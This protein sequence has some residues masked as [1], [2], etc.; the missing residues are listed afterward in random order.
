MNNLPAKLVKLRKHFHYSQKYLAQFLNISTVDYM[1]L[2]NGGTIASFA[3]IQ[4]LAKLYHLSTLV[5]FSNEAELI[6][7]KVSVSPLW[8]QKTFWL[9]IWKKFKKQIIIASLVLISITFL[10]FCLPDKK[11]AYI[12]PSIEPKEQFS[13]SDTSVV[14]VFGGQLVGSGDNSNGQL[15]LADKNIIKVSSGATFTVA[16][17]D[18]GKVVSAGLLNKVANDLAKFDNI[19]SLS[20]G[21]GHI[22]LL[23][24][25]GRAYCV[26]DDTYGQCEYNNIDKIKRIFAL[27]RASIFVKNDG[28]VLYCGESLGSS[29]LKKLKD[30]KDIASSDE[31]VIYLLENGEVG[32]YAKRDNFNLNNNFKDVVQ[33]CAGADFLAVLKADKTVTIDIDNYLLKQEV[34]SWRN[35]VAIAAGKDYL[36]ATDGKKLYGVGKNT[37]HQFK[38]TSPIRNTLP[39]VKNVN[40]KITE[41]E[42]IVQFSPVKNAYAYA[43]SIDVGTG[44]N[45]QT[46]ETTIHITNR[47][48]V[49]GKTYLLHIIAL[50]EKEYENS[51][52][53]NLDFTYQKPP[54]A[55]PSPSQEEIVEVPFSLECLTGKT[56]L[57]LEAYLIG[58]GVSKDNISSEAS[59]HICNSDEEI[60]ESI[61]GVNDYEK[62]TFSELRKRKIFYTYCQVKKG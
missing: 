38:P 25:E 56:K 10:F 45:V 37:Y 3:Q 33:V 7:P 57:N 30:I 42:V 59:I 43:V 53:L 34:A 24:N 50:G 28:S 12:L 1:A 62:I 31:N 52:V 14:S 8:F 36:V 17:L 58:L 18:N 20:A 49:E 21:R 54:Q 41:E 51:E 27:P 48:F 5:L 19:V 60:V 23:N 47:D 61:S 4:A 2:E 11:K 16:L 9:N 22:L 26:G 55:S 35:I 44:F 46:K 40:V 15:K 39:Q 32:F 13:A 6:L 29:Q